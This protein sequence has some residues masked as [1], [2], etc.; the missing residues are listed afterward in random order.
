LNGKDHY[1]GTYGT[2]ASKAE[3]DRIVREWLASGRC[4]PTGNGQTLSEIILAYLRFAKDYYRGSAEVDKIKLAVRPLRELYGRNEAEEFSPL[5]LKAVQ[6]KMIDADL[7]RRT[8]NMRIGNIKRMFKWAVGNELMKPE[9]Y[10]GLQA[11][12]GL[13]QGRSD[14]KEAKII[15]PVPEA[16]VDA[17]LPYVSR[18]VRGLIE[19]Q[20]VTGARSGELCVMRACD[21]DM[22]GRIWIYRPERHKNQYREQCREIYLGP[23]AQAIIKPFLK[24]STEAYLFSPKEAREERYRELRAKRKTPVQPSQVDRRKARPKRL[25]RER[26]DPNSYR[27]AVTD[28]CVKASVPSWHPHQLRHNAATRL[29]REFGLEISR[30]LLGHKSIIATQIYAEADRTAAMEVIAK[31][32]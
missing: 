12:D 4:L 21:I 26:Y 19:L 25:P 15:G 1:L 24:P 27:E 7:S 8:I 22:T 20:R 28:A 2:A 11:V 32:G 3:Y 13:K 29:R 16:Y 30:I 9:I 14:A 5:K 17:V 23:K 6:R 31:V 18:Q 10:H